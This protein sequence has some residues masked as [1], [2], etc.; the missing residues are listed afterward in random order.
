MTERIFKYLTKIL[1]PESAKLILKPYKLNIPLTIRTNTLKIQAGELKSKLESKGFK[2][3]EIDLAP[4][5][6]V[7][8]EEPFPISKTL[9]HFAG[10]F[11]VQSLSS[12]LP[13]LILEPALNEMILDIASA[14]GS[15]TT[16]IAQLMKNTGII[17][18]NDISIERLKVVAHQIDRLGILN[19]GITSIDGNRFGAIFPETFD[20]AI[21]D[22]PCSALGII[23]KANEVLN[24]WNIDE[25]KRLS[26]KQQ[27]LL[28]SAVK[29]VKPGGIIVYS[30]CTLTVEEN[31]VVIDSILKKFP[32]EIEEIKYKKTEFDEGIT[33]YDGLSFDERL[34][35][36][37]RIYPFKA[38]TEGFFHSEIKKKRFN[39][40]KSP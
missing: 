26:N 11:Y 35:K 2:L 28:T 6:F 29:S 39:L 14:P 32:L 33:F 36:T 13:S 10:L 31:E 40:L 17:I 7:V 18:A 25:V 15:K 30:T 23:S 20:K 5:S 9:E 22:A 12:M 3:S 37:V 16:H 4:G 27:Q 38:N 34:K 21:V 19:T 1:D 8:V 24:W